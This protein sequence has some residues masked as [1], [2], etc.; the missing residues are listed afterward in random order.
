VGASK[1]AQ[2]P[3]RRLFV[4]KLTYGDYR[5]SRRLADLTNQ[6]GVQSLALHNLDC[7]VG[8]EQADDNG[9]IKQD[10]GPRYTYE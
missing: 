6:H 5:K 10:D 1:P 3:S 9:E 2:S 8:N 7:D 4:S